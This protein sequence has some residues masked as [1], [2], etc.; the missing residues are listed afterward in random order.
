[1]TI[2]RFTMKHFGYLDYFETCSVGA[3]YFTTNKNV[4][5]K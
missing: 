4:Q 3:Q 1:M 5:T 2:S